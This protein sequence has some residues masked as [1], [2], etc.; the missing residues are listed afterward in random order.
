MIAISNKFAK[1]MG[2]FVETDFQYFGYLRNRQRYYIG[3]KFGGSTGAAP[4]LKKLAKEEPKKNLTG[5]GDDDG[6]GGGVFVPIPIKDLVDEEEYEKEEPKVP[7]ENKPKDN[8]IEDAANKVLD[9]D[10]EQIKEITK[11][12]PINPAAPVTKIVFLVFIEIISK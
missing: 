7:V 5:G 12:A 2:S 9:I 1:A 8:P 11:D 6:G 10:L 4:V 3:S